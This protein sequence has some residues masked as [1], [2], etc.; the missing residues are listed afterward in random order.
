M[1]ANS[2]QP[3]EQQPST[4]EQQD[5]SNFECDCFKLLSAYLDGEVTASERRQVQQWLDTNPKVQQ[6]YTRLLRLRQALENLP[7]PTPEQTAQQLSAGVFQHLDRKR[8][9][10]KRLLLWSGAAIAAVVIG[11]V[12]NLFSNNESP[13]PGLVKAPPTP[14][15]ADLEPTTEPLMIA[16]NRPVVEIPLDALRSQKLPVEKP[17][18]RNQEIDLVH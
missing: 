6:L 11:T 12:S 5:L 7:L 17:E 9:R 15:A 10:V 4:P 8:Q 3:K 14:V 2:K 18:A 13:L 1:N 16:L